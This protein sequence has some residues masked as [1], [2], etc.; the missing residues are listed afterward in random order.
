MAFIS[1]RFRRLYDDSL[2]VDAS[3]ARNPSRYFMD[4]ARVYATDSA[5]PLLSV[6]RPLGISA[7]LAIVEAVLE[8]RA[9]DGAMITT[10]SPKTDRRTDA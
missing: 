5:N 3:P 6:P 7:V 10:P 2:A 9:D 8:G 4:V 1:F